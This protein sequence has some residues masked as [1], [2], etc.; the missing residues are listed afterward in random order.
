MRSQC[1]FS[2]QLLRPYICINICPTTSI[3]TALV[4]RSGPW[5]VL[6]AVWT[7]LGPDV[8]KHLFWTPKTRFSQS[9]A[10]GTGREEQS[11]VS[12]TCLSSGTSHP[13]FKKHHLEQ[14]Q[15]AEKTCLFLSCSVGTFIWKGVQ[16]EIVGEN[17][18]FTV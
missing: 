12:R 14:K 13:I 17:A 18:F 15:I 1:L 16:P 9:A 10:V 4:Q 7:P 2:S 8:S 5:N 6:S 11:S 3:M